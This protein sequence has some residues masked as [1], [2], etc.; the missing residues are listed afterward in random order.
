MQPNQLLLD[1]LLAAKQPERSHML[2]HICDL[3]LCIPAGS[4]EADPALVIGSRDLA[5]STLN[6]GKAVWRMDLMRP[7][8]GDAEVV[9]AAFSTSQPSFPAHLLSLAYPPEA[10]PVA[11]QGVAKWF[12]KDGAA[13]VKRFI[14]LFVHPSLQRPLL[15]HG[16]PI[17][18]DVMAG[19]VLRG[20]NLP[21]SGDVHQLILTNS[22][23]KALTNPARTDQAARNAPR[24][25]PSR[26]GPDPSAA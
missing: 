23:A 3:T 6:S 7:Y 22:C 21:L 25:R 18:F 20:S 26:P 5:L 15:E 16:P 10:V 19:W 14:G 1:V 24:P 13:L 11:V 17:P 12:K 2:G 8:T 9:E 4:S